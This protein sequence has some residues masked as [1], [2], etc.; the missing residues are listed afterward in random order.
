MFIKE[1]IQTQF[2]I[3]LSLKREQLYRTKYRSHKEFKKAVDDYMGF[4][5]NSS[6]TKRLVCSQKDFLIFPKKV[7]I[8]ECVPK[9]DIFQ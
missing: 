5:S 4:Y 9:Y 1:S 8:L 6:K 2:L 3:F 7:L